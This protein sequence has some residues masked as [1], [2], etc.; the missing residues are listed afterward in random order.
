MVKFILK[1]YNPKFKTHHTL[2]GVKEYY[3]GMYSNIDIVGAIKRGTYNSDF[4]NL[5][6]VREESLAPL[7]TNDKAWEDY[8]DIELLK[9]KEALEKIKSNMKKH[10]IDMNEPL[11][12]LAY[13]Y[14][15][16]QK[17]MKFYDMSLWSKFPVFDDVYLLYKN[18]TSFAGLINGYTSSYGI[19]ESLKLACNYFGIACDIEKVISKKEH[20][21]NKVYLD[22]GKISYISL[23]DEIGL[24]DGYYILNKRRM[25]KRDK[26]IEKEKITYVY[27]LANH[28]EIENAHKK[29]ELLKISNK[30]AKL[31]NHSKKY[32][33]IR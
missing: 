20:Y 11:E 23:A 8:T 18:N 25:I 2:Y 10:H 21:I 22:D 27:F 13:L 26:P 14:Q 4:E 17:K 16:L 12:V 33:L 29:E 15:T 6:Y 5:I 9:L 31:S 7:V 28:K 32:C 24:I 19:C 3:N 30:S 1:N